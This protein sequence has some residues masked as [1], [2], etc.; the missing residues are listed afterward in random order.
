MDS[1]II[2]PSPHDG[3]CFFHS[4]LMAFSKDYRFEVVGGVKVSRY[5][6]VT[7]FKDELAQLLD[8]P[9]SKGGPTWYKYL[10]RGSLEDFS[11]KVV[12]YDMKS[13]QNMLRSSQSVGQEFHEYVSDVLDKDIYI[14][15]GNINKLYNVGDFELL[16]RDRP[17][18]LLYYKNGHYDLLGRQDSN[19]D[20]QT[21]FDPS[22]D[23]ILKFKDEGI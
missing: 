9:I 2:I 21:L 17:S 23:I 8:K 19:G 15:Q 10:S 14:I 6:I 20:I 11:K 1:L 16:Y 5:N 12:G 7:Q 4:V 22:D 18:I 3:N 13:L